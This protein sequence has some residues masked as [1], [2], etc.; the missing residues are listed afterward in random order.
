M[1]DAAKAK[2]KLNAERLREKIPRGPDWVMKAGAAFGGVVLLFFIGFAILTI[3][4]PSL[5]C[6]SYVVLAAIFSMGTALAGAFIGGSAAAQGHFGEKAVGYSFAYSVGGGVALLPI[7]FF[8]FMFFQPGNS[9]LRN[10]VLLKFE[11]IPSN[12]DF[13]FADSNKFW[14]KRTYELDKRALKILATSLGHTTLSLITRRQEKN[15][16][17][18]DEEC[19]IEI[20]VIGKNEEE[21]YARAPKK[22]AAHHIFAGEIALSVDR[23]W[24][25]SWFARR[26]AGVR[27]DTSALQAF[28]TACFRLTSEG[29]LVSERIALVPDRGKAYYQVT[30]IAGAGPNSNSTGSG[31]SAPRGFAAI[32]SPALAQSAAAGLFPFS[33]LKANLIDPDPRQRVTARQYLEANFLHYETEVIAELLSPN[34]NPDYLAALL[35]GVIAGIDIKTN[36]ALAPERRRN[37]N[38]SLPFEGLKN[39]ES[40]IVELTGHANESLRRQARRL[41]SRYPI[42][43]FDKIYEEWIKKGSASKCANLEDLRTQAIL[44]GGIFYYYNRVV[45]FAYEKSF[46]AAERKALDV[47]TRKGAE[48][49]K[50]LTPALKV[51]SASITFAKAIAYYFHKRPEAKQY[52]QE[53]LREL[54]QFGQ[55]RYYS[56]SHAETAK[57][58]VDGV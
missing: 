54:D 30:N 26:E 37:L 21:E 41:I 44:Y 15:R 12:F 14:T 39:R 42:D 19:R 53:F 29:Q 9:C 11:N 47:M 18:Y 32:S 2:P 28:D 4:Y 40:S 17:G 10:E 57:R 58:I 24:L 46:G 50:C 43:A 22:Y 13:N 25:K 38:V 49:A 31:P 27:Q 3:G 16:E 48:I 33:V 52:A 55:Q 35:H 8:V 5:I 20:Y 23:T 36:G 34:Q 7:M 45:Q 6:T 1:N 51:D 56:P